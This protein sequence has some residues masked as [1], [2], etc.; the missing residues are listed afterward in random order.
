MD[1]SKVKSKPYV[2]LGWQGGFEHYGKEIKVSSLVGG[3]IN[4]YGTDC[5]LQCPTLNKIYPHSAYPHDG[6]LTGLQAILTMIE[7]ELDQAE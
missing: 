1:K 4:E 2:S 6:T 5:Y 3:E 7:M